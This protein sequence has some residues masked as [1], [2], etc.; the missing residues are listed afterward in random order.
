MRFNHLY[1][2]VLSDSEE[3]L[4]P[5]VETLRFA[6]GITIGYG[7]TITKVVLKAKN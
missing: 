1:N 6:Q 3:P 4:T 5:E 2:V 7:V